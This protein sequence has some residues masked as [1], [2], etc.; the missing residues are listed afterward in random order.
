MKTLQEW[1][2]YYKKLGVWVYPYKDYSEQF[3]WLHWRNMKDSDYDE[4]F[5]TYDWSLAEGINLVT[6]KKGILVLSF[7][8]DENIKYATNSLLKFL[9]LLGLSQ[10]YDWVI[11][12]DT[13][14]SIVLDV[15]TMPMG[16]I[17]KKYKDFVIRYEDSYILPPVDNI[18]NHESHFRNGY[19]ISRPQQLSWTYLSKS[20]GEIEKIDIVDRPNSKRNVRK[21]HLL[22]VCSVLFAIA[23]L[24]LMF[25]I[26]SI[27]TS[28]EQLDFLETTGVLVLI[29]I[30]FI[31]GA[32][33]TRAFK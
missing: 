1:A 2:E 26:M 4:E 5:N 24:I 31:G 14:F 8:K 27:V 33:L 29:A 12:G 23:G 28:G 11:E 32:I 22:Q 3:Q 6:G 9:S 18:T 10:N 19:P 7:A 20:I 17:N 30:I 21:K 13:Y 25:Y 15:H 16:R